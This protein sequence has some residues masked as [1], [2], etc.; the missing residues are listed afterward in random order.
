MASACRAARSR[1]SPCAPPPLCSCWPQPPPPPRRRSGRSQRPSQ[2]GS[3]CCSRSDSAPAR[4]THSVSAHLA[5]SR[6][7]SCA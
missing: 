2:Q 3:A 5:Q 6:G 4:G 7:C 1:A